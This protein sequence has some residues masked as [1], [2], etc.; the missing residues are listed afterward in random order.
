MGRLLFQASETLP[1]LSM[2][3]AIAFP[4]MSMIIGWQLWYASR[5]AGT[6]FAVTADQALALISLFLAAIAITAY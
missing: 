3:L 1:R 4:T 5:K 6:E 2:W